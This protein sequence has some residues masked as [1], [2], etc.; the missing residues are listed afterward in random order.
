MLSHPE[1]PTRPKNVDVLEALADE[2]F[3]YQ[4]AE[5]ARRTFAILR[6]RCPGGN[7]SRWLRRASEVSGHGNRQTDAV[8]VL[9]QG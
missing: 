8:S 3:Q 2:A 4:N 6:N 7:K 9:R 1:Y 5:G